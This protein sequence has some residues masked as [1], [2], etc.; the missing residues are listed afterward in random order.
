MH[1]PNLLLRGTWL[2][3]L[4]VGTVPSLIASNNR[5]S[6]IR[7]MTSETHGVITKH[8]LGWRAEHRA[9]SRH[10]AE[11]CGGNFAGGLPNARCLP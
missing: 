5:A 3:A 4:E 11:R 9:D 2:Q 10:D 8:C 6:T 1:W 7:L